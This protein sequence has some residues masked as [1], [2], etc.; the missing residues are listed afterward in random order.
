MTVMTIGCCAR[1]GDQIEGGRL[2]E[3]GLVAS[4]ASVPLRKECQ[5]N[6]ETRGLLLLLYRIKGTNGHGLCN[7]NVAYNMHKHIPSWICSAP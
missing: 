4:L 2:E 7:D 5:K 3:G 6:G 1:L